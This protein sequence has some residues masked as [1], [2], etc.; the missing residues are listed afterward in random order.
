MI[1]NYSPSG[2]IVKNKAFVSVQNTLIS[3]PKHRKADFK[4]QLW[5]VFLIF[6]PPHL[7][8]ILLFKCDF[9]LSDVQAHVRLHETTFTTHRFNITTSAVGK[10]CIIFMEM[11][12][13]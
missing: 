4:R 6:F 7:L 1:G 11:P 5:S 8:P 10:L 12:H 2:V 9:N 3:Y 13:L